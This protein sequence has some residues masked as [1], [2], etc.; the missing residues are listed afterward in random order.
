[1]DLLLDQRLEESFLVQRLINNTSCYK[2]IIAK[3]K[4]ETTKVEYKQKTLTQEQQEATAEI[5]IP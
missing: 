3:I 4:W 5:I 1:M 2:Q